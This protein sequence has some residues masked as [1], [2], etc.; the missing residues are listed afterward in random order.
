[1]LRAAALVTLACSIAR[2]DVMVG[3]REQPLHEVAHTV[4]ISIADGVA[5][6]VVRRTFANPGK[7]ADQV[8][9]EIDLPYGSGSSLADELVSF[10]PDVV[11][12]APDEVRAAVVRRLSAITA[13]DRS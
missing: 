9:L 3:S 12:T 7:V 4:D 5:T 2:A 6:Y 10:G 11:V 13:G 8:E 1:M